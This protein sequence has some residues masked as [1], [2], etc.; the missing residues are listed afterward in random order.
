MTFVCTAP[1]AA[2]TVLVLIMTI[3]AL[4]PDL[5]ISHRILAGLSLGFLCF[6]LYVISKEGV[7]GFWTEHTRNLWGNQIWF[8]LLLM[9]LGVWSLIL[10]RASKLKM[11]ILNWLVVILCTGS[12]GVLLMISRLVYLES[13]LTGTRTSD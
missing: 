5:K 12:V 6:S 11:K 8:D 13:K 4:K 9:T 2:S 1:I 3:V 7:F 10:E